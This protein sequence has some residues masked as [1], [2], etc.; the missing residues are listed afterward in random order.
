MRGR[1]KQYLC[2]LLAAAMLAGSLPFA[3]SAEGQEGVTVTSEAAFKEALNNHQSPITVNGTLTVDVGAEDNGRMRPVMFP[4]DTLIRGVGDSKLCFRGPIQLEGDGICF[5]DIGLEFT[6]SNGLGSIPHR[7]IFLAGHSLVLDN[8]A[9]YRK[10]GD[11]SLTGTEP[12]LLPTVYA[13]G[14]PGTENGVNA[15]LT[16]RNSNDKT[17]FQAIYL[18]HGTETDNYSPYQEDAVLNLD[19]GATVR[20]SVD[21]SL[22]SQSEIFVSGGINSYA[23]V[24]EIHGNDNTTMTLHMSALEGASVQH[25]GSL[26]LREGACLTLKEADLK[27]VTLTSGSCLNLNELGDVVITGNFAGAED[28]TQERAKLVVNQEGSVAIEGTVSGTTQFQTKDR[29]FPGALNAGKS[30]IITNPGA[31][32]ES[33]FVLAQQNIDSGYSLLF[34]NGVWTADRALTDGISVSKIE[35]LS[36]PEKIDLRKAQEAEGSF[37]FGEDACFELAWYDGKGE[38]YS[39]DAVEENVFYDMGY[40]VAVKSEYW[41][42]DDPDV[43][44]KMDWSPLIALFPAEEAGKYHMEAFAEVQPGAYTF[45]FCS[46]YCED[47]LV[48]VADVK[49]LSSKVL[50]ERRIIFY[51]QDPAEPDK[52][53]EPGEHTHAYQEEITKNAN[54]TESGWKTYTC[55]CGQYYTEEIPALGH[56]EVIDEAVEPTETTEGKTE[57]SHCSV[58]N[59]VLK[60]QQTI[61]A[62]G[63]PTEPEE[64]GEPTEPEGPGKPEEPGK[65]GE[66]TEPEE[67]G[68]PTEPEEPGKPGEPT[69]PEEPGKPTEPEEHIH[70]YQEEVTKEASCEENGRKVHTCICGKSYT[71]EIP[72]LGHKYAEKKVAATL[73]TDGSRQRVCSV[74]AHS[75]DK[76]LIYRVDKV[77]LNQADYVFNGKVRKPSVSVKDIKG[78]KLSAGADYQVSYAKGRKN[79]GVY[80][81]TVTFKGDY[82]GKAAKSFTI[83][84]KGCSLSKVSAKSK[85]FRAIWKRQASQ[86]SG[87]QIQYC[88]TKN[89]KGKTAKTVTIKKHTTVRKEVSGL[90][91]KKVYFIRIRTYKTVKVNGKRKALYS[92]WSGKKHIRTK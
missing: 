43:L 18:G 75:R 14:Y 21:A 80:A 62:T 71:E 23:K 92:D 13:G 39:N 82:S 74:C 8:V 36:A 51:D 19:A 58:C 6:S 41:E 77:T 42:S 5:Q 3:V 60:E 45:L 7:E 61:P 70:A 72:S 64:P 81:V 68:E 69:E 67:P 35:V 38:K 55:S 73:K 47:E 30:Y 9:T 78:R 25:V 1:I 31:S 49:A 53:T 2:I 79:P 65:P 40:V 54:C 11:D 84:P 44:D 46:E 28:D 57:G 86:I 4:A 27:N 15:S 63:K 34:G 90:K 20:G 59:K 88:L 16:V 56:R 26:I 12:E 24:K 48:T 85:G 50:A 83:R 66:P 91:A 89:F 22:N 37:R 33:N 32:V 52:P 76:S 87:Y 17:M 10:G 29:L